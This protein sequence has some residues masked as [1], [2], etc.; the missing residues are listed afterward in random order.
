MQHFRFDQ[1]STSRQHVSAFLAAS[2]S[3]AWSNALSTARNVGG[4]NTKVFYSENHKLER[5][6]AVVIGRIQ[7][8]WARR[9]RRNQACRGAAA[10]PWLLKA[11]RAATLESGGDAEVHE[12]SASIGTAELLSQLVRRAA[13]DASHFANGL[14]LENQYNCLT[15]E[16]F[17]S[18]LTQAISHSA[19]LFVS[20]SHNFG[21]VAVPLTDNGVF[22]PVYADYLLGEL[23]AV[24][25]TDAHKLLASIL[26][27][28]RSDL[29]QGAVAAGHAVLTIAAGDQ[30]VANAV[31]TINA[32][33]LDALDDLDSVQFGATDFDK[34]DIP[35][36]F[37]ATD[38]DGE[39]VDM[40]SEDVFS[41]MTP[42][43]L[44]RLLTCSD[45]ILRVANG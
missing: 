40:V 31:A 17:R 12:F 41:P 8:L 14:A 38:I 35:V 13:T 45:N 25:V 11:S 30:I 39:S 6:V 33:E 19:T 34:G 15:V 23:P 42:D 20:V 36:P 2:G 16:H 18:L 27:D 5:D 1:I 10:T 28:L 37:L 22:R 9:K 32:V 3:K 7:A 4:V 21:N 26:S 43:T 24:P 44:S 29:R